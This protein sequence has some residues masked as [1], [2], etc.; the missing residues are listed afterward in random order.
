MSL[1]LAPDFGFEDYHEEV[2]EEPPVR[3]PP[4]VVPAAAATAAEGPLP[5]YLT[6]G[7]QA[8]QTITAANGAYE[9]LF[10]PLLTPS[11]TPFNLFNTFLTQF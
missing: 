10:N 4:A 11:N 9:P 1:L 3:P 6:G 7:S 8:S 5:W 2:P